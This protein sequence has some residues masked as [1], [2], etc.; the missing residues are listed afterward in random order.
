MERKV[1]DNFLKRMKTLGG[2][3]PVQDGERGMYRFLTHMH[4]IYFLL[5]VNALAQKGKTLN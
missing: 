4:R 1:L 3:V 5:E 2:I